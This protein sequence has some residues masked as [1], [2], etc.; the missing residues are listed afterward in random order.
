MRDCLSILRE[1][2]S[3]NFLMK[4]KRETESIKQYLYLDTQSFIDS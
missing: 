4:N 1:V 2:E 3:V